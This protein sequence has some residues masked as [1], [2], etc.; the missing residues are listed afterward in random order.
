MIKNNKIKNRKYM[1]AM[2]KYIFIFFHAK[3]IINKQEATHKNNDG[4]CGHDKM[5]VKTFCLS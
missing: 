5:V 4:R 1:H 3:N 2:F